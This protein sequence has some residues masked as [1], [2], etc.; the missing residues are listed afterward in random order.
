MKP[1]GDILIPGWEQDSQPVA[2][3]AR[4]SHSAAVPG[5]FM[6]RRLGPPVCAVLPDRIRLLPGNISPVPYA[7][8]PGVTLFLQ[9]I[10]LLRGDESA[11]KELPVAFS[12][13]ASVSPEIPIPQIQNTISRERGFL[14]PCGTG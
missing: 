13:N 7:G 3:I 12:L 9:G 6:V 10:E 2:G 5:M 11:V 8:D 14:R 4:S 1:E